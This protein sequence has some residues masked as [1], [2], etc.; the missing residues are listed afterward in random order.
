MRDRIDQSVENAL[1]LHRSGF[2]AEAKAI[3]EAAMR[4]NQNDANVI[5]LL[6]IVA[7][8]EED[9]A[10]AESLWRRSLSLQSDAFV[11]IRNQNNLIITLIEDCREAEAR[12]LLEVAEIPNWLDLGAPD[13]RELK[14]IVS[15]ALCL[16]RLGLVKK[17]RALLEPVVVLLPHDKE[18]MT[19]LASLRFDDKDFRAAL[20]ILRTLTDAKD[21]WVLTTRLKCEGELGLHEEA[22]TGHEKILQIG[23]VHIGAPIRRELK[24]VLVIN[25]SDLVIST[26]SLFDLHFRGNFPAQ[27][28]ASMSDIFN[29]GSIFWDSPHARSIDLRPDIVVNNIVNGEV[30]NIGA[31]TTSEL[32]TIADSFGAPVINHPAKAA[33][34][35]RQRLTASLKELPNV[36]VPKIIRFKIDAN[37]LGFQVASLEQKLNYPLII[38]TTTKNRGAGMV[39]IADRAGLEREFQARNGEEVYANEFIENRAAN[40]L[41]RKFRA[42][43]VGDDIIPTRVDFSEKWMVH[44]RRTPDRKLFYRQ[45][46]DL[47][48][49]EKEILKPPSHILNDAI[50]KTLS[51]I[52]K[53]IPLD[54]FGIDFDILPDGRVLFFEA[55]ASMNLFGLPSPDE[56]DIQY[57]IH[58]ENLMHEKVADYINQRILEGKSGA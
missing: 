10:K 52:R 48:E 4:A 19:L 5:G 3:Y 51:E 26:D 17:A 24:T 20:E 22:K 56:Q 21:L 34:T 38:R 23:S 46:P 40:G 18:A 41:Y 12:A 31:N 32:S 35:T 29:F 42:T 15:L 58:A 50:L 44:G 14:S 57:P 8:Q 36:L 37:D 47:L 49:L 55:N 39:L 9:R 54:I 30:L 7:I 27:I 53:R 6:G 2:V 16:Q 45:R 25:S 11:Y 13:E 33:L 1:V 43:Y 28:A